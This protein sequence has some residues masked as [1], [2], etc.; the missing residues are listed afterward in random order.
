MAD[1]LLSP[2]GGG[3]MWAATAVTAAYSSVKVKEDI[4]TKRVIILLKLK[5]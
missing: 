1:A 2:A 5:I 3:V 4:D